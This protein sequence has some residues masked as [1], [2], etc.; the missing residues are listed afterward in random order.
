ML[1]VYKYL[2]HDLTTPLLVFA[3]ENDKVC[4]HKNSYTDIYRC[5][6][7]ITKIWKQPKCPSAVEW[8]NKLWYNPTVEYHSLIKKEWTIDKTEQFGWNSN[9]LCWVKEGSCPLKNT[10]QRIPFIWPLEKGN[11][12]I[13]DKPRQHIK[14][15]RHHFADKGQYNQKL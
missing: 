7:I 8:I 12:I 3:F 11:S 1:T 10:W 5:S 9:E 6:L 4:S 2:P 13:T 14:K 15:Q